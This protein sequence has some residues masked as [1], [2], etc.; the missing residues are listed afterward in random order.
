MITFGKT[1]TKPN[2]LFGKLPLYFKT[3]DSYKDGNDEGLL[4]RYLEIFCAEIDNEVS[5]YVDELL[6][7][8]DAEALPNLTRDNPTELLTHLS[9]LFGNPPDVGTTDNWAGG[10]DPEPEY[11]TLIRYIRHIL[12][13]KGTVKALEYYLA[14]YG[15]EIDTLTESSSTGA[16][17]DVSPTP[18]KYDNSLKY[19]VR[20]I[21]YSEFDLVITD[22]AGMVH[23]P[24]PT[25][26]WLDNYLKP[27]IQNF[28]CPMWATL[29]SLTHTP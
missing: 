2:F 14:I 9:E 27:A 18:L 11:I 16:T 29:D 28:L 4:E 19:D 6:D 20:F 1:S 22:K 13:T 26:S 15:Y 23:S 5:P 12:Q 24:V 17:Y 10:P 8:T 3:D 7:I 25:Q 21:F